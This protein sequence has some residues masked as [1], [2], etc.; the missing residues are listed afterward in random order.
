MDDEPR[1]LRLMRWGALW[2][3]IVI[4]MTILWRS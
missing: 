4:G 2:I 1:D 3:G